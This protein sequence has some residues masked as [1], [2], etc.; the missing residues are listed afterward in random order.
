MNLTTAALCTALTVLLTLAPGGVEPTDD[1]AL[2]DRHFEEKSYKPAL[3]AYRAVYAAE[4][5]ATDRR[6]HALLR[7]GRCLRRLQE[8]D[9]SLGFLDRELPAFRG[10]IWQGRA[11]ALRGQISLTMPHYYYK[12]GDRISRG[13]WIQGATYH[14]TY[15]D[16]LIAAMRDLETAVDLLYGT[17]AVKSIANEERARRGADF[18]KACFDMAAPSESH[19]N[20]KGGLVGLE[21]HETSPPTTRSTVSG[22]STGRIRRDTSSSRPASRSS[23]V[24]RRS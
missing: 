22:S 14:Y 11:H 9:R 2:A 1:L 4:T 17:S 18:A 24:P 15:Y 19:R 7:I 8:Y 6:G 21:V 23:S 12:K 5:G 16:D 13:E 20:Q 3:E 10:T